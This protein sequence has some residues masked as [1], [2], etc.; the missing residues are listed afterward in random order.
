MKHSLTEF[1]AALIVQDLENAKKCQD[2][3]CPHCGSPL[4]VANFTRKSRGIDDIETSDVPQAQLRFSFCCSKDG[5]RKRVTPASVRFYPHKVYFFF[6]I[7]LVGAA[8][9]TFLEQDLRVSDQ[10]R[11]R[12]NQFWFEFLDPVGKIFLQIK[13]FLPPDLLVNRSVGSVLNFFIL[14][15][16]LEGQQEE[17]ILSCLVFFSNHVA[18]LF[19]G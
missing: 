18:K 5:C 14:Q 6:V 1:L 12:W 7:L 17:G 19:S 4:H 15:H 10:T 8:F 11:R 3:G 9:N 13:T 2:E 16:N